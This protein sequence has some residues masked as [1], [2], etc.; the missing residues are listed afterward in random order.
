MELAHSLVLNEQ[1]LAQIPEQKQ[2]VFVY[3]WLRFLDKVLIAAHKSDI[4]NSQQ[5]IVEQMTQQITAGPG[6]PT[7]HLLGRCLATIFS[8]G[9]TFALFSTINACNDI[10]KSRDDSPSHLP[11]RLAAITCIGAMYEKL[12]RMV[13]RSF[14]ETTQILVRSLKNA[15]VMRESTSYYGAGSRAVAGGS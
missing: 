2:P 12:G 6:P 7:R 5:K 1:A 4:K 11:T 15:E 3:E 10:L 8:V 14:E 13:G 9:D